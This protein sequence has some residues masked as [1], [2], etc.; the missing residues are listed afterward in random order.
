VNGAFTFGSFA[1]V[2]F[3]VVVVIAKSP[4]GP[5]ARFVVVF[6]ME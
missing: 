1:F 2:A 4:L 6:L 5:R 3:S